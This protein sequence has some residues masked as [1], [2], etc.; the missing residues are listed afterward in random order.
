MSS[1]LK[2]DQLQDSG[3]NAI[4]TSD[5]SGNLTPNFN[6]AGGLVLLN[7]ASGSTSIAQLDIDS[8]YINSSYNNYKLYINLTSATDT[9]YLRGRF[10]V[11]GTI[12]SGGTDYSFNDFRLDSNSRSRGFSDGVNEGRITTE[13]GVGNETKQRMNCV[14]DLTD[15]TSTDQRATCRSWNVFK[16]NG[17]SY[18]HSISAMFL[19]DDTFPAVNGI[20]F[21]FSSGNIS[22]YDYKLYGVKG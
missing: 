6:N 22:A 11:D 3:G 21:F 5:G 1:I 10:F 2:V 16:N 20:R 4:I 17:D 19:D 14:I 9:V 8:T 18:R 15:I 7:S 13:A 12:R